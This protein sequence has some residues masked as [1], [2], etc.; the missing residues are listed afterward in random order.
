MFSP[1][2][3]DR[4]NTFEFRVS[5]GDL[6]STGRKPKPCGAGDPGLVSGLLAIA[7]DPEWHLHNPATFAGQLSERLLSL[8]ALL[9]RYGYEFG[10]RT[11]FEALRFAAMAEQAGV[12]PLPA[13][14]DRIIIQKILPRLHGARRRLELPLLALLQFCGDLPGEGATDV[15]LPKLHVEDRTEPAQLPLSFDKTRRMLQNLRANQF[16]SFTE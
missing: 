12:G 13:V 11:Y 10:H 1:K 7:R 4:A 14:L 2:V 3:L 8:H 15:E 6:S 9:T 5:G 16:V